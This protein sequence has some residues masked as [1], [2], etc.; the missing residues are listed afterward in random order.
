M[1]HV[2]F[3]NSTDSEALV[4]ILAIVNSTAVNIGMHVSFQIMVFSGSMPRGGIAGSY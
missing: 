2:F 1:Y 4:D 3:I